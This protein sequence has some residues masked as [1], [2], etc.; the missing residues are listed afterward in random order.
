MPF[1][2]KG[3]HVK[4][5][6]G[7]PDDDSWVLH[8]YQKGNDSVNAFYSQYRQGT[9]ASATAVNGGTLWPEKITVIGF[10]MKRR[11]FEQ[12]HRRAL[13]W[14]RTTIRILRREQNSTKGEIQYGYQP[15]THNLYGC[16]GQLALERASKNPFARIHP[17]HSSNPE[18][19]PLLDWCPSAL[20]TPKADTMESQLYRGPLPWDD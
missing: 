6:W 4:G 11:R 12:L 7:G 3:C 8:E 16:S 19:S 13:R 15:F 18:L 10:E 2:R 1:T 5:D 20:A 17:Y 14:P 9:I